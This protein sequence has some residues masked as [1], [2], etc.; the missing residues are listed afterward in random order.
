MIPQLD[1]HAFGDKLYHFVFPAQPVASIEHLHGREQELERISRALMAPGRHVFIF[2]DRGVGKSSLAATAAAQHQSSDASYIDVSGSPDSTLKS[3][4]AN[5][6]YQAVNASRIKKTKT[7]E[8][9]AFESK[10]AKLGSS[11]E[12][13]LHDLQEQIGTIVDAVEMLREVAPLHSAN[14]VVVVDEFDRIQSTE[15]RGRFADLIKQLGDKRIP[16][17]FIFTGVAKTIEDL[18][19]AHASAVR[20]FETVE[21]PRL[22]WRGRWEI[23]LAAT[24]AFGVRLDRE[25]YLRIAAVSDGFPYYVHLI[26]EKMLWRVFDDPQVVTEITWQHYDDGLQQAIT[27]IDAELRRPYE[28]AVNQRRGDDYEEVLWSSAD[29]DYLQRFVKDM[30]SS[31]EYVMEQRPDRTKLDADRY[32]ARVR[33]LRNPSCGAILVSDAAKPGLYTYREKMLRGFVRMQAEANGIELLG[34]RARAPRPVMHVPSS[35]T[36]GYHAS[37]PPKGVHMGRRRE[38]EKHDASGVEIRPSYDGAPDDESPTRD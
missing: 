27:G 21:L 12:T 7:S 24:S 34:E 10:W 16:I 31:Y 5:V 26:T 3:V 1:R 33:Q 2:G 11:R 20:Q 9:I 29:S 37:R 13:A 19:G 4:I 32:G 8:T 22:N 14:P 38:N 15:E 17:H 28:M 23:A 25:I 36:R 6:V 30:Y 35:V 18:L